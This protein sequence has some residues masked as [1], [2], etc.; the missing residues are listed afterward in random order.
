MTNGPVCS[1]ILS[2]FAANRSTLLNAALDRTLF[3]A[4]ILFKR[5]AKEV[6]VFSAVMI[7]SWVYSNNIYAFLR[8]L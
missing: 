1:G 4:I 2:V 5:F 7:F 3:T 8:Q 6:R